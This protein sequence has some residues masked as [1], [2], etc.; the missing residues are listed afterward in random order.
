MGVVVTLI[1]DNYFGYCKKEV[2]SQISYACN[3]LGGCEEEHA[4][5]AIAFPSY[6]HG[7]D[8]VL[9]T[10]YVSE[11]HTLGSAL[12]SLGD[13]AEAHADGYAVDRN[14]GNIIYLPADAKIDQ[15]TLSKGSKEGSKV[16]GVGPVFQAFARTSCNSLADFAH[17]VFGKIREWTSLAVAPNIA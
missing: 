12:E 1:A 9:N 5:G 10:R 17:E 11:K 3:L 4:G 15:R 8:F 16:K 14:Y 13:R 2:K 7:E 6:D